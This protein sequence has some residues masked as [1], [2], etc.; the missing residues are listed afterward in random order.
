VKLVPSLSW[1]ELDSRALSAFAGAEPLLDPGERR[2]VAIWRA[3]HVVRHERLASLELKALDAAHAGAT[4]AEV[5]A[6]FDT[7]DEAAD[8]RQAFQVLSS[9]EAR[10]WLE[11]VG[12]AG[13]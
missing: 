12:F 5:C 8:A 7:G 11:S 6:L 10:S 1:L 2:A 13:P 3:G 4:M 9:W